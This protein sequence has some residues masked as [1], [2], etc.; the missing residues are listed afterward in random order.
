MTDRWH[1]YIVNNLEAANERIAA[2]YDAWQYL[3]PVLDRIHARYQPGARILEL[4][5]GAG[6]HAAVLSAWGYEVT[7]VDNDQR[8]VD[9][10]AETAQALGSGFEATLADATQLPE[11]WT[12]KFDLVFSLGLMEHFDRDVTVQLLREQARVSRNVM[13]VVPSRYTRYVG[14]TD[15]RIYSIHGWRSIFRDAGLT[16]DESLVF[17]EPPTKIARVARLALPLAVYKTLQRELTYG[18]SICLFG[19]S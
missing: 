18:M 16:I 8:I 10:A 19:K 17:A 15:E 1:S 7:A 2:A 9:L 4:G 6:L 3:G 11:E 5:C 13:V 14:I 12:G